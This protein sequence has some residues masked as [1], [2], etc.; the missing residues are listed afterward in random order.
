MLLL[1]QL[2]GHCLCSFRLQRQ[3]Q[4]ASSCGDYQDIDSVA[5]L[6]QLAA[7]AVGKALL[8]AGAAFLCWE[9]AGLTA[10]CFGHLSWHFLTWQ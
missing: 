8:V 4:E 3:L 9:V 1:L 6:V 2:A 7:A 10:A 5:P